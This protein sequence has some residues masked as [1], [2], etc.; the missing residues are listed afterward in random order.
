M[1]CELVRF[2]RLGPELGGGDSTERFSQ[3]KRG[4]ISESE[5]EMGFGK[6]GRGEISESARGEGML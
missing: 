2:S 1:Y 6:E 3:V 5:G 4:E